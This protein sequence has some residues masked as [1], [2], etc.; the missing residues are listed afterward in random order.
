M[1]G[2]PT[3][4]TFH[5]TCNF[6]AQTLSTVSFLYEWEPSSS[7]FNSLGSLQATL[8][9]LGAVNLFR[10]HIFHQ[11]ALI[12]G[13]PFTYPGRDGRLSQGYIS[14]PNYLANGISSG[15][16]ETELSKLSVMDTFCILKTRPQA[17][18]NLAM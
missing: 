4:G 5:V 6:P 3:K 2:G 8:L 18:Y 7:N 11:F 13:T 9:H 17:E 12:A 10:M 14:R 1:G 16:P 15:D